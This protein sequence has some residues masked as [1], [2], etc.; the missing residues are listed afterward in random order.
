MNIFT[1]YRDG[2]QLVGRI[3]V[4]ILFL[5][6]GF[7]KISNYAG[8][9]AYM[10]ASGLPLVG[11]LEPLTILTEFGGA[12]LVILGLYTRWVGLLWFLF[13]IPVTLV[14]HTSPNAMHTAQDQMINLMKNMSIMGAALYLMANGAGRFSIDQRRGAA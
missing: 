11:L 5:V 3:L 8:T 12:I 2:L 10:A 6:A 13:L 1:K 7:G 4:S 9:G 14:F